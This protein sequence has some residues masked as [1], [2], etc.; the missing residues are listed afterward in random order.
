MNFAILPTKKSRASALLVVLWVIALLSF[1]VVTTLM[2]IMQDVESVGARHQV[3][4]ARQLAEMGVAVASNPMVKMG[5][6]LL[7]RQVSPV[8]RYEAIISTEESL[9]NINALLTEQRRLILERLF[10]GKG[11][12]AAAAQTLVNRMLDWIDGDEL[13]RLDS[14][15]RDQYEKAGFPGRPYDRPFRSLDEVALVAGMDTLI[16][17][18]PQW[19]ESFTVFGDGMLDVNEASPELIAALT[20]VSVLNARDLASRRD[21]PDGRR[22][23]LDDTPFLE[24]GEVTALLGISEADMVL[25]EGLLT[26]KGSTR[27][28]V[29]T[30]V[31][32]DYARSIT[33][34]VSGDGGSAVMLDWRE[35]VPQ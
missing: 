34:L 23:T 12:E 18:W 32:G 22:Y 28:V 15:E 13:Q 35:T 17:L 30:G 6:P 2:V 19:R 25:L 11:L 9:L 24:L 20:G 5:D 29:S 3:F 16:E 31:A 14:M 1:L 7:G 26:L 8:E 4:R 21:G 27:R 33:V 10:S